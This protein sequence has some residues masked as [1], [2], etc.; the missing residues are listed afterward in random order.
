MPNIPQDIESVRSASPIFNHPKQHTGPTQGRNDQNRNPL[1]RYLQKIE[2][3]GIFQTMNLCP[4][5]YIIFFEQIENLIRIL[6]HGLKIP[7]SK[8]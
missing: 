8:I 4:E 7:F 6:A 1:S 2:K 5:F 3:N